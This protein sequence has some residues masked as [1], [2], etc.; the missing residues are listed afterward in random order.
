MDADSLSGFADRNHAFLPSFSHSSI[1]ESLAY[2]EMAR[3]GSPRL[4]NLDPGN[5]GGRT[6]GVSAYRSDS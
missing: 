5:G 3:V 2:A 6:S 4:D 1:R